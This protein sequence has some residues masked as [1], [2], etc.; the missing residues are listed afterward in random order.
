MN[1]FNTIQKKFRINK[2]N[3]LFKN[4]RLLNVK[5]HAESLNF[6]TFSKFI[7]TK[8]VILYT[9]AIT[10]Y[11]N[12]IGF[13]NKLN[14][15]KILTSYLL[16][17][18][19]NEIMGKENKSIHDEIIINWSKKLVNIFENVKIKDY[20]YFQNL[21]YFIINYQNV[22]NVWLEHD[23]NKT[24]HSIIKSYY[25]RREH[26]KVIENDVKI[27]K[28]QQKA[29]IGELRNQCKDL[30]KSIIMMDSKFNIK[31][32]E[33]NYEKIH[34]DIIESNKLMYNKISFNMK[35]AFM[36]KLSND[37]KKGEMKSLSLN[38]LEIGERLMVICPKKYKNSFNKKFNLDNISSMLINV[39][40]QQDWNDEIKYFINFLMDT[41]IIFDSYNNEK[42]NIEIKEKIR[43]LMIGDFSNIVEI[44]MI[45]NECIDNIFIKLN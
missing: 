19:S 13:Q 27:D 6:D 39:M 31:F 29:M 2:I 33:K 17:F 4:F 11:Y 12:K 41:I 28:L 36:D 44:I 32:F 3:K 24:I 25:Y 22:L 45:I 26:I 37:I 21:G 5:Q 15:Q 10:E 42:T 23:K 20:D 1:K 35:K 9:R 30:L 38:L 7:R 14:G 16:V 34:N 18:F 43:G 8:S 40:E